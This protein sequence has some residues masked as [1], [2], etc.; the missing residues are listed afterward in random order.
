MISSLLKLFL[1]NLPDSLVT[2]QLYPKFIDTSKIEDPERRRHLLRELVSL[3]ERGGRRGQRRQEG[4][5]AVER[6]W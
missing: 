4:S 5:C 2:S 6:V 3:S 1:R